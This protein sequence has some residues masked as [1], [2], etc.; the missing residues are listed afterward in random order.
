MYAQ[1]LVCEATQIADVLIRNLPQRID[2]KEAILELKQQDYQW[3]QMEWVGW[4]FEYKVFSILTQTLGGTRGPSYGNTTFDY[5]CRYIWDLKAH[6]EYTTKG[7]PNEPMILNDREA[8]E[9]CITGHSGLGFVVV[10]GVAEFDSSGEFKEWHDSLKGG[11]SAY[12]HERVQRGAGSRKRKTAFDVRGIDAYFIGSQRVLDA[13]IEEG[14]L[15]FFQKGMRNADGSTRRAKYAL[16][17]D[18]VPDS[19]KVASMRY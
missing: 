13:G 9:A 1:D 17:T 2:G 8:V 5:R 16:R 4:Y 10:R 6:P 12:E 14:W 18:R 19:L 3:R 7:T 15:K 11:T